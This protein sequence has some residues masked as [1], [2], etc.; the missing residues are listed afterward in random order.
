MRPAAC[1]VDARGP[2]GD[3]ASGERRRACAAAADA[4]LAFLPRRAR[5][6]AAPAAVVGVGLEVDARPVAKRQARQARGDAA[7]TV[8]VVEQR[9]TGAAPAVTRI[10]RRVDAL[11]GAV[12]QAAGASSAELLRDVCRR[13]IAAVATIPAAGAVDRRR[14]RRAVDRQEVDRS[15]AAPGERKHEEERAKRQGRLRRRKAA[16]AATAGYSPSAA[17]AQFAPKGFP[18]AMGAPSASFT[19]PTFTSSFS[20]SIMQSPSTIP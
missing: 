11:S 16:T 13:G 14:L 5:S 9:R 18:I 12:G 20:E 8:R 10:G 3:G 19:L 2:S 17:S 4:V 1:Q 7:A 6:R 15:V